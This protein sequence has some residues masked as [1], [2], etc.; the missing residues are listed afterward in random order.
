LGVARSK[1]EDV[2]ANGDVGNPSAGIVLE[3]PCM[4]FGDRTSPSTKVVASDIGVDGDEEG[5]MTAKKYKYGGCRQTA[6]IYTK[7]HCTNRPFIS[8]HSIFSWLTQ[9]K[10]ANTVAPNASLILDPAS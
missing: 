6:A 9:E 5:G 1:L 10:L 8:R 2:S 4:G 7:N 3:R